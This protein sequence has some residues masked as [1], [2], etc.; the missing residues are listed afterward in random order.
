MA[1]GAYAICWVTDAIPASEMLGDG[2]R[3]L[4]VRHIERGWELPGGRVGKTETCSEA[5]LRELYEET[6]LQA[7]ILAQRA[8]DDGGVMFWMLAERNSKI[9]WIS[10]DAAIEEVSWFSRPPSPLA[11]GTEELTSSARWAHS[12]SMRQQ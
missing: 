5:A 6:G 12:S 11:W 8:M 4:M 2:A 3:W 1:E 10:E 9:R 7:G